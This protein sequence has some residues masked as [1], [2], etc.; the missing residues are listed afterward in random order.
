MCNS[1]TVLPSPVDE[2]VHNSGII[3]PLGFEGDREK[4]RRGIIIDIGPSPC[5]AWDSLQG[6]MVVYYSQSTRVADVEI[7]LHEHLYAYE[8]ADD[9]SS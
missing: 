7:V 9:G 8:E 5:E 3:V 6:G 2:T 1:I 4:I